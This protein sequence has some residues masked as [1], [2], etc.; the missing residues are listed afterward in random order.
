MDSPDVR[1]IPFQSKS[2]PETIWWA[3]VDETG[4]FLDCP[5]PG[6]QKAHRCWHEKRI[7]EMATDGTLASAE[8]AP[9]CEQGCGCLLSRAELACLCDRCAERHGT[10]VMLANGRQRRKHSELPG[11]RPERGAPI[12]DLYGG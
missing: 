6:W 12:S 2:D 10:V 9:R 5:C 11:W 1:R 7:R 4:R 3:V 8:P